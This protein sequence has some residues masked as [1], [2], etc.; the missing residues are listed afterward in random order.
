MPDL[1]I[2]LADTPVVRRAPVVLV[3]APK[4]GVEGLLLLVHRVVHVLLA[5]LSDRF[6]T[7]S[8]PCAHRS[9]LH[10]ELPSSA[11]CTDVVRP[12]KSNVLGF[13]PCRFAC[14]SA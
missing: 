4:L 1:P 2:E 8:E 9:H 14:S 13:F 10:C 5:P 11:A 12:R 3:V 6:Q 7:P